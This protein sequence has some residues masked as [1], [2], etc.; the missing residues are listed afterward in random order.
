[1]IELDFAKSPDGLL[2]VVTQDWRSGEVLMLAYVNRDA[3]EQTLATGLAT[4]WSRS[5]QELWVKGATSG[6]TQKIHEV[7]VDCDNDTILYKVE[8]LGGSACHAGYRSCFFR[9]VENGQLK[10][11]ATPVA[12]PTPHVSKLNIKP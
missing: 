2:P 9:K 1:M 11:V 12:K 4:Y 3:F 7:L 6:H 8:Q 5:R 10:I